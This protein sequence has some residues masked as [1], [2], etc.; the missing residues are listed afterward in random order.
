[1]I[2][3]ITS[4]FKLIFLTVAGITLLSL[5]GVGTLAFFGNEEIDSQNIPVMQQNLYT[6]CSFG[7][8]AGFG[9]ILGLLGGKATATEES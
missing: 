9:A 1:M 7:W 2:M 6:M 8:Q 5:I 3:E 4:S